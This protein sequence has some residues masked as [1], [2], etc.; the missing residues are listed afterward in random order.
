MRR[1]TARE[2]SAWPVHGQCV[3]S[4]WS[5][6]SVHVS[7]VSTCQ[8]G[9]CMVSVWSVCG[10][11]VVSMVTV[12]MVSVWSICC[13]CV[14]SSLWLVCSHC[15]QCPVS[16][17]PV[18]RYCTGCHQYVVSTGQMHGECMVSVWSVHE[19]CVVRHPVLC[20]HTQTGAEAT[21]LSRLGESPPH[22]PGVAAGQSGVQHFSFPWGQVPRVQPCEEGGSG[23]WYSGRRC[24]ARGR[25]GFYP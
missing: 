2:W 12:S 14:V 13:Q 11:Y 1:D 15:G 3:V 19:L 10:Q 8:C 23:S 22:P 25:P 20:T 21:D 16:A 7:V 17:W 6:W 5:V 4:A 18:H 9:Q 24:L